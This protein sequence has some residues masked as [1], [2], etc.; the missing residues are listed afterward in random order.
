VEAKQK[1]IVSFRWS[2]SEVWILISFLPVLFFLMIGLYLLLDKL[3]HRYERVCAFLGRNWVLNS[4]GESDKKA[5][6]YTYEELG[7]IKFVND[8]LIR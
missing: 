3:S 6:C 8:Q 1:N 5:S 7:E 4:N 2:K